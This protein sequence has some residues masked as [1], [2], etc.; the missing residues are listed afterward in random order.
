M[1]FSRGDTA[2]HA[3]REQIRAL[4]AL[5]PSRRLGLAVEMSDVARDLALCGLR[6]REPSLGEADITRRFLEAIRGWRVAP[7]RASSPAA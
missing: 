2:E 3:E 7:P 1:S 4:T 5:S 6:A